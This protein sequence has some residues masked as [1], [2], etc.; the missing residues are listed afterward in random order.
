MGLFGSKAVRIRE[1]FS[2]AP[3]LRDVTS[4]AMSGDIIAASVK[5]V[6]DIRMWRVKEKA[7]MKTVKG[8][9][10]GITSLTVS[11][12]GTLLAAASKKTIQVWDL[13]KNKKA[14][15]LTESE[16]VSSLAFHPDS[17]RIALGKAKAAIAMMNLNAEKTESVWKL[18][19]K[20][21]KKLF[22]KPPKEIADIAVSPDGNY[23]A[24]VSDNGVVMLWKFGVDKTAAIL[25]TP[26]HKYFSV[27]FSPDSRY[28]FTAG[29][30]INITLRFAPG[31]AAEVDIGEL[32]G[33]LIVYDLISQSSKNVNTENFLCERAAITSDGGKI[34]V[35]TSSPPL[36]DGLKK[37][38]RIYSIEDILA[39]KR[40]ILDK[41]KSRL[42]LGRG[43][44]DSPSAFGSKEDSL[45]VF[46]NKGVQFFRL[47]CS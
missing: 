18:D 47:E 45:A 39:E 16:P 41:P 27:T 10:K 25:V 43:A 15:S 3:H 5:D 12:D 44:L 33:S 28:M 7:E 26:P 42:E 21:T 32:G 4:L 1:K 23:V 19:S 30:H 17:N 14:G 24:A 29:G 40:G 38:L 34:L 22:E 36:K 35:L 46:L 20:L 11:E 8:S 9:N 13:K 6:K 31:G 37:I 2:L